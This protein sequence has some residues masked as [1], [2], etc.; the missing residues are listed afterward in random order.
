MTTN[1]PGALDEAVKS[2]VHIT[3]YY[4]HLS[5]ADTI[6]LFQMNIERL[7]MI[8]K[9]R[10]AITQEPEM[11]IEEGG[12]IDYAEQH[13]DKFSYADMVDCRWN[14]RQIRNAFQIAAS[15]ARYEHFVSKQDE[16]AAAAG[17]GSGAE[18]SSA[19]GRGLRLRAHHFNQVER[20]TVEYDDF[21]KKMLGATDTELAQ[22]KEERGPEVGA[23]AS[24]GSRRRGAP[25]SMQRY[26]QSTPNTPFVR[27][28]GDRPAGQRGG[29]D[30]GRPSPGYDPYEPTYNLPRR[31]AA[32]RPPASYHP[33]EGE[34][35]D[36][37]WKYDGEE[38][39]VDRE[40]I[41]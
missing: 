38:Q 2:R 1:R 19:T 21:R 36:L 41:G 28:R 22:K 5:K 32:R 20:A 13:F 24:L 9:Q 25:P 16:A 7:K 39:A 30:G 6:S 26:S 17:A 12:I 27:D 33:Y 3:L 18:S 11:I 37:G 8:E 35:D 4:P 10:T 34:D 29:G 14:G 31:Q 40:R 15:L 23:H